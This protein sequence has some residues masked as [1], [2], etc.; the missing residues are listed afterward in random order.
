[1]DEMRYIE[2]IKTWDDN[3]NDVI[4]YDFFQDTVLKAQMCVPPQTTINQFIENYFI[5]DAATDQL[6]TNELVRVTYYDNQGVDTGNK[7]V[8]LRYKEFD[9]YVKRTHLYNATTDRIKSRKLLI[10]ERIKYLLLRNQHIRNL[11]F[12]YCNEYDLWT[13][14]VG[15][16]RYHLVFTYKTT[17]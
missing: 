6:L 10:A 4:R 16:S 9:I 2:K 3:W 5:E 15:Y 17:V 1:M 14:T 13:K 12:E 7:N 8:L 11:H